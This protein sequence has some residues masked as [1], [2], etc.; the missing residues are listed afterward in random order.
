MCMIIMGRRLF[1]KRADRVGDAIRRE[2]SEML[3]RGIKDPRV[4]PVTITRVHI[5]D[6]LRA[7]RVYFSVMGSETDRKE[8]IEGLNS[9]KG[10]IKREMGR[11]IHLRYVPDLVFEYDS[12]VEYADHINR[13]IKD[14]QHEED[15]CE[16]G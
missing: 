10:Y 6:D 11:R 2:I 13:L 9:A 5:S 4:A 8:S 12:S 14:L 1:F 3:I 16:E 15:P 7:A